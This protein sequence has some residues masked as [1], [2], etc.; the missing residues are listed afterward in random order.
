M[1]VLCAFN[2]NIIFLAYTYS[3]TAY[4]LYAGIWELRWVVIPLTAW[5]YRMIWTGWAGK[6][7]YDPI[8]FAMRDR[9]G[10]SLAIVVVLGLYNA[11]ALAGI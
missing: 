7:N 3:E 2:A 11:A 9:I 8:V 1:S 10:L 5:L 6:Q 4:T